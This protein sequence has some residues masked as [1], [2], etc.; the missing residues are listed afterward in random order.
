MTVTRR[1]FMG[2]AALASAGLAV[3]QKKTIPI[4]LEMYSVR[5]ALQTDLMGT[6][7]KVALMGYQDMEFFAPYYDWSLQQT[8]DVRKLLDDLGVQCLST[9]NHVPNYKPE[10]IQ[11]TIDMNKILGARFVVISTAGQPKTL[12]GW[13]TIAE[14][15]SA[16][17]ELLR[18]AG[19]RGGYHNHQA[20][21]TPVEG[22]R[23]IEVLAANTPKDFMMQ[24][25]VGTCVEIGSDPAAWIN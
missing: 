1:D 24:F 17:A 18:P 20:E 4:G 8:K 9:H 15:L 13:K 21:F 2:G 19:L 12:D 10:N 7:R 14:G 25:D 16:G 5:A 22:K 3:A 11:K 6:I 23:P